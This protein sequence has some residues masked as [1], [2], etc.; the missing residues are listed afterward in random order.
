MKSPLDEGKI[1]PQTQSNMR[2]KYLN[3]WLTLI[4]VVNSPRYKAEFNEA[5]RQGSGY[6]FKHICDY[7]ITLTNTTVKKVLSWIFR[8]EI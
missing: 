4:D 5:L 7:V 8:S 3:V 6:F 1:A 2:F